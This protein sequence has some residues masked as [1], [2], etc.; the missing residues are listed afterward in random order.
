MN[1]AVCH[2]CVGE[3][4]RQNE[5]CQHDQQLALLT[6]LDMLWSP[7]NVECLCKEDDDDD[8]ER[9]EVDAGALQ[10]QFDLSTQRLE[11]LTDADDKHDF[12]SVGADVGETVQENPAAS[13]AMFHQV[14]TPRQELDASSKLD[15]DHNYERN[16]KRTMFSGSLF[17]G[18]HG[19][20]TPKFAQDQGLGRVMRR[21]SFAVP[22]SSTRRQTSPFDQDTSGP[23]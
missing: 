16:A 7:R 18:G 10:D 1:V 23:S 9:T 3:R 8:N 14:L 2:R 6:S 11:K 5:S 15:G 20:G 4:N 13:Q 12:E 21:N 19:Q 22:E 17:C